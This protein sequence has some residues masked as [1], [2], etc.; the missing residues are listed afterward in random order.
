MP[1]YE[2]EC[3]KCGSRDEAYRPVVNRNMTM[4][5]PVGCGEMQRVYSVPVVSIWDEN[6][7]FPNAVKSG[8]G[9]FKSRGAYEQH[10]KDNHIAEVKTD[11]KIKRPHG[12]RV[13]GTWK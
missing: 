2:Y 4:L 3:R 7:P 13:I 8:P 6:R 10:L 1:I 11:G 9:T 12:N 5:C